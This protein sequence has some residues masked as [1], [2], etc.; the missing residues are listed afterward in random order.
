MGSGALFH[1]RGGISY[2]SGVMDE[3]RSIPKLFC[4]LIC[5]G[6]LYEFFTMNYFVVRIFDIRNT[7]FYRSPGMYYICYHV[8]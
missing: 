7:V 6:G 3:Y 5:A 2:S 8:L 4:M 1:R